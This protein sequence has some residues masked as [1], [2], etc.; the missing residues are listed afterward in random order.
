MTSHCPTEMCSNILWGMGVYPR[1]QY[2]QF[3]A[4]VNK[5]SYLLLLPTILPKLYWP[6]NTILIQIID[7][8]KLKKTHVIKLIPSDLGLTLTSKHLNL[9][10]AAKS[11]QS[12]TYALKTYCNYSPRYSNT[13]LPNNMLT[14]KR[15]SIF[16]QKIPL[17]CSPNAN[18]GRLLF[19]LCQFWIRLVCTS[20]VDD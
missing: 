17:L 16:P 15:F 4:L 10:S 20:F 14:T 8:D 7:N 3:Q 18:L 13:K 5:V 1:R 12:F 19:F 11:N 9:K 2:A 6:W